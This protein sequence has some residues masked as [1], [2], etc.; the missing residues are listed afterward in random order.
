LFDLFIPNI[1]Y[2]FLIDIFFLFFNSSYILPH[3]KRWNSNEWK[4][5]TNHVRSR[6]VLHVLRPFVKPLYDIF[7]FY[8]PDPHDHADGTVTVLHL[9]LDYSGFMKVVHDFGLKFTLGLSLQHLGEM[10]LAS[11]ASQDGNFLRTLGGHPATRSSGGGVN[12]VSM[13]ST[14]LATRKNAFFGSSPATISTRSPKSPGVAE[15]VYTSRER[16]YFE[17]FLD[18]L[19]RSAL[20]GV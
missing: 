9:Y 3:A 7:R 6:P 14:S 16:M 18:V 17:G 13:S 12:S 15:R 4:I 20:V 10:F 19:V 2:V 5:L 11:C 8:A 1:F